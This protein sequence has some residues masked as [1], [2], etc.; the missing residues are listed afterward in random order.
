MCKHAAVWSCNVRRGGGRLFCSSGA[1]LYAGAR[2]F[3]ASMGVCEKESSIAND[4]SEV[5]RQHISKAIS[6]RRNQ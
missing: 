5:L 4:L 3:N 1:F 6:G 2:Y